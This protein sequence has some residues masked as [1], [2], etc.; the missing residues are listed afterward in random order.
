MLNSNYS[1]IYLIIRHLYDIRLITY[2]VFVLTQNL[3][4]IRHMK[5]KQNSFKKVSVIVLE[6]ILFSLLSH[7]PL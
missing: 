4:S 3:N 5:S 7:L 6:F 1:F 2:C